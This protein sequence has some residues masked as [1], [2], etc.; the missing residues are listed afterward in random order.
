MRWSVIKIFKIYNLLRRLKKFAPP[1][2]TYTWTTK[3]RTMMHLA[4]DR[5]MDAHK[6]A[7]TFINVGS[8]NVFK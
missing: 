8:T 2:P 4:M 7:L 6:H 1:L 3:N 5:T